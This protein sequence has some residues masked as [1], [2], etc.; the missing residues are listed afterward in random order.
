MQ[1]DRKT[2]FKR[3]YTADIK[4]E[5]TAFTNSSGGVIYVGRDDDGNYYPLIRCR[6]G[7]S[8]AYPTAVFSKNS[9]HHTDFGDKINFLCVANGFQTEK[10]TKY[11]LSEQG[12]G[13]N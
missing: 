7:G 8:C 10:L 11:L 9:F 3:E 5:V 12:N 4:K 13:Q 6:V 2:E 1:E